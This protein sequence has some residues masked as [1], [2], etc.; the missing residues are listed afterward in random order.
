MRMKM[1]IFNHQFKNA[2]ESFASWP[3]YLQH[4]KKCTQPWLNVIKNAARAKGRSNSNNNNKSKTPESNKTNNKGKRQ[5][6][7][8]AKIKAHASLKF[9]LF[10][11]RLSHSVPS[12]SSSTAPPPS[13]FA[14][15]FAHSDCQ[16]L[17]PLR[18]F[19][20]VPLVCYACLFVSQE[21]NRKIYPQLEQQP[22]GEQKTGLAFCI[23]PIRSVAAA[24]AAATAAAA[25][26]LGKSL[27]SG[28]CF[29]KNQRKTQS[30]LRIIS[31]LIYF[32]CKREILWYFLI[33]VAVRQLNDND[34]DDDD[35]DEDEHHDQRG[36]QLVV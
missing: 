1:K 21:S 5:Q 8:V 7:K 14:A 24:I 26:L 13:P 12:S 10:I 3:S 16:L 9:Y 36:V 32:V 4:M 28:V 20:A 19:C 15:L 33:V 29:I 11:S 2:T 27:H 25:A 30:L 31:I 35:G 22:E 23:L 17:L 18:P 34:D 6:S